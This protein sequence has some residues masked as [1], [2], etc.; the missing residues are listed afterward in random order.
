MIVNPELI[1]DGSHLS[2][3]GRHLVSGARSGRGRRYCK[4]SGQFFLGEDGALYQVQG[5]DAGS[6]AEPA[7][8]SGEG[9]GED[10]SHELGRYFLGAR[11]CAL[12]GRR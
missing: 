8:G 9:L 12:Q 2:R 4:E 3:R 11:W 6:S 10:D 5:F 7:E 1:G